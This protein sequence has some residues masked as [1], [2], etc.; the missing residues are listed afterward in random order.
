MLALVAIGAAAFAVFSLIRYAHLTA[1]GFD[2]GIFDQTVW[3]YSRFEL[4]ESSL[5]GFENIWG[6]HFSPILILLAPLYWIW[7]DA[8]VLLL[9][10]A[11]L[12]AAAAVPIF[13][14]G[15]A[16]LGRL[17]AYLFAAAY[18][19]FWGLQS[20]IDFDFH[21]LAFAPLLIAWLLLAADRRQWRLYFVLLIAL[22]CVKEDQSIV[23]VFI[24]LYLLTLRAWRPA[25]ATIVLGVAWYVLVVKLLIP[26]FA[27]SGEYT[28]FDYSR[29]GDGPLE[30]LVHVLT[31]PFQ[32]VEMLVD[33]A[34]KRSTLAYLF[35]PFLGLALCSRVAIV[36]AP[37]VA[38]RFLADN[39]AYWTTGG[40]YTLA[41]AAL[42]SIGAIDGLANVARLLPRP[43]W[44]G[45]VIAGVALV[46]LALNVACTSAASR[47]VTDLFS[48]SFYREPE[49]LDAALGAID[50]VPDDVS[51]ATTDNVI[52][53][54]AHRDVA[55]EISPR[56]GPTDY[57]LAN[58]LDV[59]QNL[60]ANSG[61]AVMSKYVNAALSTH[62]PVYF[63]DGWLV[64]RHR[65]LSTEPRPA[66]LAPL[67]DAAAR[68][69]RSAA[70]AWT[71]A[72]TAYGAELAACRTAAD[73][74]TCLRPLG[75]RFRDRHRALVPALP[76]PADPALS[77]GCAQLASAATS[78]A[79]ALAGAVEGAR[80][81]GAEQD[82]TAFA[83]HGK[84]LARLSQL[85]A[86]GTLQ[87]FVS[88]CAV[89]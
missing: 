52:V 37:L 81:A 19:L 67:P 11:G 17:P 23:A 87:R 66:A 33:N 14:Y 29:L 45:R 41:I 34:T 38:Q 62:D 16:R 71:R 53:R 63:A 27:P 28:Y 3:R 42:L 75:Q 43:Q 18:L 22:L 25:A 86:Q 73:G 26:H 12:L 36:L 88:L 47:G 31:H 7:D 79:G 30:A 82:Q 10:Q 1:A 5:K 70:D 13:L 68:R 83:R 44:R 32:T 2:L 59:D 74:A 6:D 80:R 69:V 50:A 64:L 54:L 78:A 20:A 15:R 48:A 56:T 21:E 35:V 58:V 9:A 55:A 85:D 40:H 51:V 65:R 8:R 84:E 39:P 4:P 46:I 60:S 57:V 72:L 89:P 24:G 77:Q 76:D 49:G 61:F